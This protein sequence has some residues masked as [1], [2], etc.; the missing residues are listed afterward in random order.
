MVSRL[1]NTS[2]RGWS[3]TTLLHTAHLVVETI[4]ERLL[5]FC[6]HESLQRNTIEPLNRIIA[7]PDHDARARLLREWASLKTEESKYI[8]IAVCSLINV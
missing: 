4:V 7:A 2:R 6:Y 5:T 1:N 8:Q 3:L